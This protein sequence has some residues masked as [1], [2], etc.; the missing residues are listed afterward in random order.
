MALKDKRVEA[1]MTQQQLASKAGVSMSVISF[2]ERNGM[3]KAQ[4][5][6][7]KKLAEVLGC[8]LEDLV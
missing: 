1:G 6:I 4:V 3:D 8:K 5:R 7:V 2:Y